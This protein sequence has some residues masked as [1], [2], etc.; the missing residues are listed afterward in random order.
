MV[1]QPARLTIDSDDSAKIVYSNGHEVVV[2][3]KLEA[4]EELG[5]G[6]DEGLIIDVELRPVIQQIFES[7]LP[8]SKT[9][10]LM[11][12]VVKAMRAILADSARPDPARMN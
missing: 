12:E 1:I 8:G 10:Q 11:L 9:S 2:S 6:V 5:R 7:D 4:I 3:T